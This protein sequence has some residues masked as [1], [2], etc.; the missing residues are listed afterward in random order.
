MTLVGSTL[1]GTTSGGG[2]NSD[3]TVFSIATS[4][5]SP[6]TLCSFNGSNGKWPQGGLTLVGSTLYGTT[7][8]GG[9][10]RYGTVFSIATSGGSPTALCS[11]N[12]A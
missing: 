1:Y 5:G 12:S 8:A 7:A 2:A 6:T 4:G 10:N 3:G 11:F 9:P